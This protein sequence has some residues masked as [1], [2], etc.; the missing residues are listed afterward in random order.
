[1]YKTD[2]RI[3]KARKKLGAGVFRGPIIFILLMIIF[4][5]ALMLDF[6][7]QNYF[8]ETGEGIREDIYNIAEESNDSGDVSFFREHIYLATFIF[9]GFLIVLIDFIVRFRKKKKLEEVF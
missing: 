3:R 5:I 1:M 6:S 4:A 7:Q 2:L 8:R 9:V